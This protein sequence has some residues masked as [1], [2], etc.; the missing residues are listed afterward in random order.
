MISKAPGDEDVEVEC[1][2]EAPADEDS[3]REAAGE[4]PAAFSELQEELSPLR[5]FRK[6]L[7]RACI[8]SPSGGS[9]PGE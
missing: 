7:L 1:M 5:I 4:G 2:S 8:V 3:E 6:E 9:G